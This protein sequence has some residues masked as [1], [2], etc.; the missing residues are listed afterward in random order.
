MSD[1]EIRYAKTDPRAG[2]NYQNAHAHLYSRYG[3]LISRFHVLFFFILFFHYNGH[4]DITSLKR[5]TQ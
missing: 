1:F 4:G 3:K 2:P 5:Q